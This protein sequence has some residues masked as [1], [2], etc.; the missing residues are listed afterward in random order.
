MG[1]RFSNE[2]SKKRR[3]LMIRRELENQNLV[4][5]YVEGSHEYPVHHKEFS[6]LLPTKKITIDLNANSNS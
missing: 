2:M 1:N 3:D 4:S 5:V 6:S